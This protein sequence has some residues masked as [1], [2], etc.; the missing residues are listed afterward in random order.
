LEKSKQTNSTAIRLDALISNEAQRRTNQGYQEFTEANVI[1]K[2]KGR[3][4]FFTTSVLGMNS[5]SHVIEAQALDV[6]KPVRFY[7]AFQKFSRLSS[8]EKRYRKLLA[9]HI[10][11]YLFGM[12]DV[13]LWSDPN[14]HP[15]VLS[16]PQDYQ[17]SL[18]HNWFVVL[19]NPQFVSMA[20]VTRELPTVSRPLN[21]PDKLVYRNFEG[22]W[23]YDK[24]LVQE[25]ITILDEY[26]NN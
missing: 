6:S 24:E 20:L 4:A 13:P 25:I 16:R 18:I 17:P 3:N 26:I 22:F 10:P 14:L 8:Q 5:I 11:V 7:A 15:V 12:A 2:L 21:A 1:A 19:Y 9:A 23:T